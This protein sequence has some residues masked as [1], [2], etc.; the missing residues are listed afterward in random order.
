MQMIN[1]VE[2][3]YDNNNINNNNN[4]DNNDIPLNINI[5]KSVP[6]LRMNKDSNNNN[7]WS[8]T[9]PITLDNDVMKYLR[10]SSEHRFNLKVA[11][12]EQEELEKQQELDR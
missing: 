9:Q 3:E 10:S 4:N 1:N 8:E 11:Q 5:S 7:P 12:D 2:Q 6:N